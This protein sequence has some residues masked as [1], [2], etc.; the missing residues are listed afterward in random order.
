MYL[1]GQRYKKKILK[2]IDFIYYTYVL[3]A[4]MCIPCACRGQEREE[5]HLELEL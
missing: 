3:P 4:R 1:L 5:D 2:N